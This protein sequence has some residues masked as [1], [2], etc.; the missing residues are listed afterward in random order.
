MSLERPKIK[1]KELQIVATAGV[2]AS[3]GKALSQ[4]IG[5]VL[6]ILESHPVD[7]IT[8]EESGEVRS[9]GHYLY[10]FN[11]HEFDELDE[12]TILIQKEA[13]LKT[14]KRLWFKIDD[15]GDFYSGTFLF[16]SEW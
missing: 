6:Q 10:A 12:T 4:Y 14:P 2:S 16:P 7:M 1:G 15:Q 11:G 9:A 5:I 13:G 3:Y 8:F